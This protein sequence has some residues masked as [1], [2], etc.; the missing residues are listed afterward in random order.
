MDINCGLSS[1]TVLVQSGAV[2]SLN[3]FGNDGADNFDLRG[4]AAAQVFGGNHDDNFIFGGGNLGP[5]ISSAI[6]RRRTGQ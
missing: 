2:V 1:D 3:L 5:S 4:G 6:R